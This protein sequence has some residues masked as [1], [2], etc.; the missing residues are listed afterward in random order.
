MNEISSVQIGKQQ[1][2]KFEITIIQHNKPY[3]ALMVTGKKDN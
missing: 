1:N 2:Q 3:S